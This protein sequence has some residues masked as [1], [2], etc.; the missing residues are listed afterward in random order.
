MD[1]TLFFSPN[2][3][4]I[5]EV[6]DKLSKTDLELEVEESVAGFLGV[7]IDR[8]ESGQIK[9]TQEGLTKQIIEAPNIRD[10]PRKF[11]PAT[12]EPLTKD[13]YGDP[14]N[15]TYNYASIIGMLQ[16]SQGHSRPDITYAVSQCARFTHSPKKSHEIALERIGQYLKE[17]VDKGLILCPTALEDV[18][19]FVDADF[20]G[21]WPY[22]DKCDPVSVKSR[23]GYVIT[24]ASCPVIWT[25][26]LQTEIALSTMEGEYNALSL[27]MKTVLPFHCT[28]KKVI[29]SLKQNNNEPEI[30]F[31]V[32][33]WEDNIGALTLANLEPGRHTPRSKHYGIKI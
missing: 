7:H 17:I 20:S 24:V 12:S 29:K 23:T 4:F 33:I 27:C 2:E 13:E 31:K 21:L 6:I 10:L 9:L 14:P 5:N 26:K 19:V 3:I 18:D 15:S 25:S 22:E 28:L 16:Y 11:I 32:S 1:D 8:S 30:S